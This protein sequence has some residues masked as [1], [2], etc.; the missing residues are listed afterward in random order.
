VK[1]LYRWVVVLDHG[2]RSTPILLEGEN[3]P[4]LG[5]NTESEAK[6]R[7]QGPFMRPSKARVVRRPWDGLLTV[8][9]IPF[10]TNRRTFYLTEMSRIARIANW[11]QYKYGIGL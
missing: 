3:W 5:F 6:A 11:N 8:H 9:A 10:A 4:N 1:D 2:E 7:C